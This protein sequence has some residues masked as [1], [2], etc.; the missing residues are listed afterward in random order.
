MLIDE[1]IKFAEKQE[2]KC[3]DIGFVDPDGFGWSFLQNLFEKSMQAD[4]EF[5]TKVWLMERRI[6][7][8]VLIVR[9]LRNE[10]NLPLQEVSSVRQRI[11]TTLR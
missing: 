8:L 9:R 5:R 10:L 4:N 7:N 6:N 2:Q 3:R 11:F 1:V